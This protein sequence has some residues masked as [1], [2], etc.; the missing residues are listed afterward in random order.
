MTW[1]R[2]TVWLSEE[3]S[4]AAVDEDEST[5]GYRAD[6]ETDRRSAEATAAAG[7]AVVAAACG[8][9]MPPRAND[10]WVRIDIV[11]TGVGMSQLAQRNLFHPFAQVRL[12][13]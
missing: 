9:K 2:D 10:A 12:D 4:C 11:D 13:S 5:S 6:T 1:E 7:S 3:W 8:E